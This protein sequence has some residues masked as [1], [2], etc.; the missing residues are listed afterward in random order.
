MLRFCNIYYN[1]IMISMLPKYID[2]NNNFTFYISLVY[3]Y[4]FIYVW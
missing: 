4:V 2:T 3:K 1:T